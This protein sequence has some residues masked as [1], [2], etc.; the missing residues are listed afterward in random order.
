MSFVGVCGTCI[1]YTLISQLAFVH[2]LEG[3]A[4]GGFDDVSFLRKYPLPGCHFRYLI[5]GAKCLLDLKERAVAL[6]QRQKEIGCQ[7]C[8]CNYGSKEYR[9]C[10]TYI[11]KNTTASRR[12]TNELGPLAKPRDRNGDPLLRDA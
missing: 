7:Y 3:P 11:R 1:L 2:R 8:I 10:A 6:P 9:F 5:S 12:L 4:V